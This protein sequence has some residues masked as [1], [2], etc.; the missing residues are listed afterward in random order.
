MAKVEI[1]RNEAPQ[2]TDRERLRRGCRRIGCVLLVLLLLDCTVGEMMLPWI[3][4]A[5]ERARQAQC[6]RNLQQIGAALAM[7]ANDYNGHLPV[8]FEEG[9]GRGETDP[10]RSLA[11][12]YPKYISD[13][14]GFVCPSANDNIAD[15]QP[16]DAFNPQPVSGEAGGG[17]KVC[18]YGYDDTKD[19]VNPTSKETNEVAVAADAPVREAGGTNPEVNSY[20]HHAKGQNVLYL[21]GHVEWR[22]TPN[23]GMDG[24]NIFQSDNLLPA[25]S[26]SR[27]VQV[28]EMGGKRE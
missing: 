3:G 21:G 14:M 25:P 17:G 28:N 12:L 27:V 20:N 19:M 10:M 4:R 8:A 22:E 9:V 6:R 1:P 16:G 7:Y 2:G 5:R 11:L 18:S 24:D 26:D 13:R 15:L 23:C